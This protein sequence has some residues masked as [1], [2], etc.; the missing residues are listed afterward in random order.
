M[1]ELESM[2]SLLE[3]GDHEVRI[4]RRGEV[5]DGTVVRVSGDE[6]MIDVGLK[7]EG[8][9]VGRELYDPNVMDERPQLTIGEIIPVYVVQPEGEGA[10][11]LSLRRAMQE[12]QWRET[13]AIYNEGKI[14]E[15]K[16]TEFNKGGV[17]VG[18]GPRGF[19]PMSQLVSLAPS[20]SEDSRDDIAERLGQLVGKTL[21]M[22]I[23]EMDRRRNRLI[24]SER[25]AQRDLRSERRETLL[26]EL[27]VGQ[28]RKGIVSNLATF[29]AF[30][31]LGGADGLAHISELSWS[32]VNSPTEVLR[33]GQEVDVYILALDREEKKIALSIRRALEDPWDALEERLASEQVVEGTVT[34]LA[35]FGVF[36]RLEEGVEG[37]AHASDLD[38]ESMLSMYEGQTLDFRVLSVQTERRRIRLVPA[39]AAGRGFDDYDG[40]DS[41]EGIVVGTSDVR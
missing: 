27:R 34:K 21:Q 16:V 12:K 35:P 8:V 13:E 11:M 4:L 20:S 14:I 29:G 39:E 23:I 31:D 1:P 5:I 19:V 26:E 17:L 9:V 6:V 41:G 33:P 37:L 10:A 36:V 7:S 30:I 24:L 40:V 2:E 15:A 32:R 25:A 18:V 28:I 3:S 38:E 22:K